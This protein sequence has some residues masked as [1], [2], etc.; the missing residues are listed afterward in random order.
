MASR[1]SL[2]NKL[3]ELLGNENVY[4]KPPNTLKMQY[5]A[6]KYSRIRGKS[7]HADDAK[8]ALFDCYEI[9]VISKTQ[10]NPVIE[11]ILELPYSSYDR[12]YNS[13]NLNHDVL[14]LYNTFKE[15]S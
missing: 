9:V 8:Y 11:K 1:L 3:I 10:D 4:Y 2:H 15:E 13:D 14:T 7:L 6:I 5:P 12:H